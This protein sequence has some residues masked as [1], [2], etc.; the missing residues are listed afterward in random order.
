MLKGDASFTQSYSINAD[1]II[2]VENDFKTLKG[3]SKI[4][5]KGHKAKLKNNEHSNIYKFGNEF[6]IPKTFNRVNWYGR[7]SEESYEDKKKLLILDCIQVKFL[8]CLQCMQGLRKMEIEQMFDG[9][10]LRIKME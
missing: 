2:K 3:K 4:G 5:L 7:G 10:A 1:G 8:I 6:V 9:L